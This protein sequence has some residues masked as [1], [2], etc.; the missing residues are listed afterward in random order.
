D[1]RGG[2]GSHTRPPHPTFARAEPLVMQ[3]DGVTDQ[4]EEQFER[5]ATARDPWLRAMGK[6]YLSSYAISLGQLDGAED[7]CRDGLAQLRALGEQWGVAMSLTQLAEFTELR[8]DH[9]ASVAA[10]TDAV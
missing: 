5:Y 1:P 7:H 4:A 3:Y 9:A 6:V 10:L 8:A 2:V